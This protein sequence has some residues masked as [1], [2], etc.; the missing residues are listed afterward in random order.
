MS[1]S[2]TSM[3]SFIPLTAEE[4]AEISRN[5]GRRARGPASP[6][7]R[8]IASKDAREHGMCA[9]KATMPREESGMAEA[10]KADWHDDDRPRPRSLAASMSRHGLKERM[11]ALT[12]DE[13]EAAKPLWGR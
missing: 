3:A 10:R 9:R 8:P 1:G 7:G 13:E 5:H 11:A 4:R 6:K 2:N 12:R